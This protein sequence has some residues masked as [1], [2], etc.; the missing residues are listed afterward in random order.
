MICSINGLDE[1]EHESL[2]MFLIGA[3]ASENSHEDLFLVDLWLS[4][5]HI[6]YSRRQIIMDGLKQ[7]GYCSDCDVLMHCFW[8]F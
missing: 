3:D 2:R 6:E 4:L 1:R 5:H 8:L 7:K